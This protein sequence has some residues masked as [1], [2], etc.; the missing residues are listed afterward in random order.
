VKRPLSRLAV[1][2][3]PGSHTQLR[4]DERFKRQANSPARRRGVV[5]CPLCGWTFSIVQDKLNLNMTFSSR[6]VAT[7]GSTTAC[8]AT[9]I[10]SQRH[11]TAALTTPGGRQ[12]SL[13][14]RIAAAATGIERNGPHTGGLLERAQRLPLDVAQ[15]SRQLIWH[16]RE[17]LSIAPNRSGSAIPIGVWICKEG[18]L[19]LFG[20]RHCLANDLGAMDRIDFDLGDLRYAHHHHVTADGIDSLNNLAG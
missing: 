13:A 6:T 19:S 8:D 4:A 16:V 1:P 5:W 20:V 7:E 3:L 12:G 9:L 11:D 15:V 2:L 10:A 14:Q 18:P 17:W